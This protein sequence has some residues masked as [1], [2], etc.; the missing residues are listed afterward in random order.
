MIRNFKT[1][2]V[3]RAIAWLVDADRTATYFQRQ[4][5]FSDQSIAI[6]F[7]TSW[8]FDVTQKEMAT[9]R[10]AVETEWRAMN[11]TLAQQ[12][13]HEHRRKMAVPKRDRRDC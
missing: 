1:A 11:P 2:I 4:I 5:R 10:R 7:A 8:P 12:R 13:A 6:S 9:L 3:N